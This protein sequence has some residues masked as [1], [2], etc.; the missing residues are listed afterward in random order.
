[1]SSFGRVFRVHTFGES[2]CKGVG[3]IIDGCPPGLPLDPE[4]DIQPQLTRRR[5]GQS[6][7]TTPRNEED[8]VEIFSGT[9][10]GYTIGSPICLL[11][12]NKDQRPVDY[13]N[14]QDTPR[15]SHADYSYLLKY[16]HK[17]SSGGGRSSARETIGMFVW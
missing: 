9:E 12:R 8:K 1:M 3:C 11:V 16:G 4:C 15:P 14:V 13:D 2:H 17:S 5:P 7:I 6:S 10:Q